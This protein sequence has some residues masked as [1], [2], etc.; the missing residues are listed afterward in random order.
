[1]K[2]TFFNIVR[3][4]S[5]MLFS[6]GNRNSRI[7]LNNKF[8]S[9]D[10]VNFSVNP[11][12]SNNNTNFELILDNSNKESILN[13]NSDVYKIYRNIYLSDITTTSK[14]E[15]NTNTFIENLAEV[16]EDLYDNNEFVVFH[17]YFFRLPK[18]TYELDL[19]KLML[20]LN[21]YPLGYIIDDKNI[22][23]FYKNIGL[24]RVHG[25]LV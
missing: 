2:T 15:V 11:Q 13:R 12:P 21:K 9:T 20:H 19:D 3:N 4:T 25:L 16:L 14:V 23:K 24:I 1:M 7:S 18:V 17:L 8:Y 5:A 10:S 6:L 22:T